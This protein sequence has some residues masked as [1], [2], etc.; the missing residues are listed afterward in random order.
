[1][2]CSHNIVHKLATK[3]SMQKAH[4]PNAQS[5]F[6]ASPAQ[7]TLTLLQEARILLLRQK[8]IIHNET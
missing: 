6:L 7:S 2:I 8:L 3:L 1:M 4:L 5:K